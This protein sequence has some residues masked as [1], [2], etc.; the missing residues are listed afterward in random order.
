MTPQERILP[1]IEKAWHMAHAGNYLRTQIAENRQELAETTVSFG[2]RT[3][4]QEEIA[5]WKIQ[6]DNQEDDAG[7][8]FDSATSPLVNKFQKFIDDNARENRMIGITALLQRARRMAPEE[9]VLNELLVNSHPQS[10]LE[11]VVSAVENT[12][13]VMLDDAEPQRAVFI[14]PPTEITDNSYERESH[15]LSPKGAAESTYTLFGLSNYIHDDIPDDFDALSATDK[16]VKEHVLTIDE[17]MRVS[18][19]F[20]FIGPAHLGAL[21]GER[22]IPHTRLFIR[23]LFPDQTHGASGTSGPVRRLFLVRGGSSD[24]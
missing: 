16:I 14:S 9:R 4:L 10:P 2:R 7:L 3:L 1:R 22:F 12:I 17:N 11:R 24:K 21:E 6:A 23:R 19:K 5:L 18:L 13:L 15:T 20:E 8:F